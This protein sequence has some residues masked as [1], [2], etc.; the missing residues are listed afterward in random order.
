MLSLKS[1]YLGKLTNANFVSFM[2]RVLVLIDKYGSTQLGIGEQ[3]LSSFKT[4]V[5]AFHDIVNHTSGSAQTARLT[6]LDQ[7][8]DQLYRYIRNVLANAKNSTNDSVVALCDIIDAKLLNIYGADVVNG[9]NSVES[10][11]ITGFVTDVR[12][13]LTAEQITLL[14][15]DDELD[16]L[17]QCNA[18][19][20]SLFVARSEEKAQTEQGATQTLRAAI[21]ESYKLISA[22]V[23]YFASRTDATADPLKAFCTQCTLFINAANKFIA[24]FRAR[25]KISESLGARKKNTSTEEV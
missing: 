20:D 6:E 19:Y 12:Q 24:D 5:E 25:T 16:E 2:E 21:T 10:A 7:Q 4:D 14:G 15:I 11:R 3:L 9:S 8:R 22:G 23:V 13:F 17:L 1:A 18:D